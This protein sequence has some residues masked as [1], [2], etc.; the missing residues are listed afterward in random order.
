[1]CLVKDREDII[2]ISRP[3][4]LRHHSPCPRS[5][6]SRPPLR[7]DLTGTHGG[8]GGK[9]CEEREEQEHQLE[10]SPGGRGRS[11]EISPETGL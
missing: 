8:C 9:Q 6:Q 1:M 2:H 5:A 7:H 3:A 11:S 4:D 10:R